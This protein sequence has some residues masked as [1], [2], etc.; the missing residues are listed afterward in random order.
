MLVALKVL[1]CRRGGLGL[2]VGGMGAFGCE[3]LDGAEPLFGP[4][5]GG[6]VRG[7]GLVAW[8]E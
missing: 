8:E 3:W 2:F 7:Y 6:L 4:G 5:G 1:L